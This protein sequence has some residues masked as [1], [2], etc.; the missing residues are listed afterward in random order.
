MKKYS[1]TI[2]VINFLL[3][4]FVILFP[5]PFG[6]LEK[7]YLY[8]PIGSIWTNYFVMP[9]HRLVKCPIDTIID[10]CNEE[11]QFSKYHG[12]SKIEENNNIY[13]SKDFVIKVNYPPYR[14]LDFE[15]IDKLNRELVSMNKDY[16]Y[17]IIGTGDP[18]VRGKVHGPF[19]VIF[20]IFTQWLNWRYRF[21]ISGIKHKR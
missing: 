2:L 9:E 14:V 4:Y 20:F 18:K 7:S 8:N 11:R 12:H 21:L 16:Y 6:S 3:A 5:F 15:R 19:V 17:M 13:W 10:P 1:K